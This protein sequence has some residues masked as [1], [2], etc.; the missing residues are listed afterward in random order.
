MEQ[1]DYVE[2]IL[3]GNRSDLQR[4]YAEALPRIRRL[5]AD[6]GGSE[7]DA[8]DIFQDAVLIVYQKA[9]QP[10]FELTSL[11]ST[12]FFGICRNLWL[13]RR[14]KKSAT[15]E[16][17]F[18]DTAKYIAEPAFTESDQL[19]VER[20]NLFWKA[21]RKLGPDCQRVLELFFQKI[22]MET[23][24]REMGFG[25]EGYARRRKRQCKNRLIELVKKDPA[26]GELAGA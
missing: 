21:F 3:E 5:I 15:A 1:P 18:T 9:R 20:G 7:A 4:L 8:P 2:A 22:A 24:A 14:T 23:I 26:Y 11:F 25:S 17:T 10:G 16:V 6:M 12:Y 19:Q 13:N